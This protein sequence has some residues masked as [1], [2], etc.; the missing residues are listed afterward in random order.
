MITAIREKLN[1]DQTD[2]Q[3]KA[4]YVKDFAYIVKELFPEGNNCDLCFGKG[5]TSF[6]VEKKQMIVCSCVN[7]KIIQIKMKDSRN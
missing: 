5:Y 2:E 4:Q 1:I 6:D 3:K 7:K